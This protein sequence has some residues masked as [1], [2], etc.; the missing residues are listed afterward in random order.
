MQGREVPCGTCSFDFNAGLLGV[1]FAQEAPFIYRLYF[2]QD[3]HRIS[4]D[5]ATAHSLS[6][7]VAGKIKER[8][9]R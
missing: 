1:L 7:L 8:S 4:H 2:Y 3:T 9:E 6:N 5:S